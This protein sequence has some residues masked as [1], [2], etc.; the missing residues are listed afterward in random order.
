[1]LRFG[2]KTTYNTSEN[3]RGVPGP[4]TY[5]LKNHVGSE[6]VRSTLTPRRPDTA[7][8]YGRNVP[9]PGAYSPMGSRNAP[10]YKYFNKY[11]LKERLF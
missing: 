11:L 9:G 8:A 2:L 3:R 1:M 10:A 6:G 4:G 7:P 5:N